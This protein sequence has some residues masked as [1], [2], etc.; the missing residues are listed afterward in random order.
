MKRVFVLL[1]V[2]ALS[3]SLTA[4]GGSLET[5]S[6]PVAES[7]TVET[8]QSSLPVKFGNVTS[9]GTLGANS[10]M[11]VLSME[12]ASSSEGSERDV[13]IAAVD[14]LFTYASEDIT[15]LAVFAYD[16]NGDSIITFTMPPELVA[17][18]R[19]IE[20]EGDWGTQ[21]FAA[22]F[23][24]NHDAYNVLVASTTVIEE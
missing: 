18:L 17:S 8:E 7:E 24:F 1:L 5:S 15:E 23:Y 10:E 3:V 12:E 11:I 9:V 13:Y 21:G 6:A 19:Q 4:C 14:Y 2:F 16:Q 20:A 22:F